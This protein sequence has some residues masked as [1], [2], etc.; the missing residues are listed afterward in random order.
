MK[1]K[2][3]GQ[4]LNKVYRIW[5]LRK[6]LPVFALELILLTAVLYWIGRMIF[7]QKVLEN[8]INILF[9]RPVTIF[10]FI[11]S[12]FI[13]TTALV[14]ILTL[15]TALILAFLVRHLTQGILRFILVKENYFSKIRE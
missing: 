14:K 5:L 15:A 2:F 10:F 12:A 8:A 7:V 1:Y 4:I 11:T 9:T 3:K 13:E 6:F